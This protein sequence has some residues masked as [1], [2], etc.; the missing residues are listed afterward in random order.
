MKN[1][2]E[3]KVDAVNFIGT[4]TVNV[5]NENM[6]DKEFRQFI[7]NTLPIVEKPNLNSIV[8]DDLRKEASK[9]YP[10]EIRSN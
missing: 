8:N 2:P 6:S 1:S 9:Y 5:D 10:Y 4:I 3:F 7:M